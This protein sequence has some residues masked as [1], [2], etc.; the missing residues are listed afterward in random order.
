MSVSTILAF[1][2]RVVRPVICR[3]SVF[4]RSLTGVVGS[5]VKSVQR[6]STVMMILGMTVTG[7]TGDETVSES[8]FR[9][10]MVVL[11]GQRQVVSESRDFMNVVRMRLIYLIKSVLQSLGPLRK[12]TQYCPHLDCS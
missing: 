10:A 7:R 3:A 4:T 5:L 6:A 11:C 2:A 12:L 8:A 9:L 1:Q